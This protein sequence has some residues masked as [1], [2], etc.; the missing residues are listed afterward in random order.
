MYFLQKYIQQNFITKATFFVICKSWCLTV[1]SEFELYRTIN[2]KRTCV[3]TPHSFRSG[4]HLSSNWMGQVNTQGGNSSGSSNCI[5]QHHTA[6]I[7]VFKVY[8]YLLR[9]TCAQF[10]PLSYSNCNSIFIVLNLHLRADSMCT[11]QKKQ[12]TISL[13][14]DIAGVSATERYWENQKI[15]VDMNVQRDRFWA[16]F[17]MSGEKWPNIDRQANQSKSLKH[18]KQSWGQM[19]YSFILFYWEIS[20]VKSVE[21]IKPSNFKGVAMGSCVCIYF[22]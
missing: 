8:G 19:L 16:S 13:T 15:R 11:K 22:T 4:T 18:H 3:Q 20:S 1:L 14:W 10:N 2:S 7:N 6:S 9:S 5:L 17:W 21:A 12:R